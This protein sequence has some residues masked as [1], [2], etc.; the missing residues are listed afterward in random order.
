MRWDRLKLLPCRRPLNQVGRGRAGF[1]ISPLRYR[2]S[3]PS[4]PNV[5]LTSARVIPYG[6]LN[7]PGI[8]DSGERSTTI[9]HS[10]WVGLHP[11]TRHSKQ[12]NLSDRSSNFT[13]NSNFSVV[14]RKLLRTPRS[15]KRTGG[16]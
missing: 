16:Y 14:A 5:T 15:R 12:K 10:L 6:G 4:S 2:H 9:R 1:S 13:L 3:S 8:R 7:Q 11:A